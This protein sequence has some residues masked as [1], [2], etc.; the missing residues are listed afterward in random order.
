MVD[1][2]KIAEQ[3]RVQ[4][5]PDKYLDCDPLPDVYDEKDIT[6]FITQWRETKD[7]TL[8]EAI[9]NCQIAEN[10]IRS[11]QDISGEA[12]AMHNQPKLEWCRKY[13]EILREIE[14]RKFD[15]I[16]AHILEYME[17]YTKLTE[18]EIAAN[19]KH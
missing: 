10:V 2:A 15:E 14:L 4:D 18:E 3:N 9:D 11:L 1:N 17:R 7:K 19:K 6:T 13:T 12:L 8:R 5:L 16:S